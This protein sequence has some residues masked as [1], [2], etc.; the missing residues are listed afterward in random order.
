MTAC[1]SRPWIAAAVAAL[2][3]AGDASAS[4]PSRRP[5][6][7]PS[8]AVTASHRLCRNDPVNNFDPLG[9]FGEGFALDWL[10]G[11]VASRSEETE[12]PWLASLGATIEM[13]L[14]SG[15]SIDPLFAGYRQADHAGD[16]FGSKRAVAG[17]KQLAKEA[18]LGA[19]ELTPVPD[20]RRMMDPAEDSL[21]RVG[22]AGGA[23]GKSILLGLGVHALAARGG[24][25]AAI[26][27]RPIAGASR[28]IAAKTA[29]TRPRIGGQLSETLDDVA[30]RRWYH[31]QLDNI[32][33]QIDRTA[34]V[35]NQAR[36]AFDLRN[37]A[38][39]N[40]RDLMMDQN[41][42]RALD[43]SDPIPSWQDMIRHAQSKGHEGSAI[44]DYILESSTRSRACVDAGLRLAR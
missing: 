27:G 2:A 13:S 20:F 19:L 8:P 14:R 25:P 12:N 40:A 37:Q 28:G 23:V 22:Y 41:A 31:Q 21:A 35:R 6:I 43:V 17:T 16:V 9:L 10:A 34:S 33:G 32:P 1:L 30:A 24:G 5:T 29:L 44:W 36:Q 11:I 38:K 39:M 7:H 4:I 26:T 18:A 42:V 3:L 15:A